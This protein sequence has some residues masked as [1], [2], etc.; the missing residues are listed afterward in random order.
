M[1]DIPTPRSPSQGM[2]DSTGRNRLDPLLAFREDGNAWKQMR[3]EQRMQTDVQRRDEMFDVR[4]KEREIE[5]RNS[6]RRRDEENR[7]SR[8]E[9][10]YRERIERERNAQY[11]REVQQGFPGT[12][13]AYP[14]QDRTMF[15]PPIWSAIQAFPYVL[16]NPPLHHQQSI[17]SPTSFANTQTGVFHTYHQEPSDPFPGMLS[18]IRHPDL[19]PIPSPAHHLPYPAQPHM[20][21]RRTHNHGYLP[22]DPLS[23]SSAHIV[24]PV[25]QFTSPHLLPSHTIPR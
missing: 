15:A 24:Y 1:T 14:G 12:P 11:Q 9:E 20:A 21:L 5:R 17:H 10:M 4:A 13:L 6:L 19:Y 16:Q 8:E 23:S 7:R 3:R 22:Q 25:P 2:E 18:P